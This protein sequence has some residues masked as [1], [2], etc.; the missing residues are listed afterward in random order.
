MKRI[1]P[2]LIV[3]AALF[4]VAF[5]AVANSTHH[6][7]PDFGDPL[8]AMR[9]VK[10]QLNLNTSQQQQWDTAVAQGKAARD[11][12]RANF[13]Q[14]KTALQT[15]LAKSEP[16][17]AAAATVHDEMEQQNSSLRKQAR[18]AWL[19]LYGTFTPDQKAVVRDAIQARIAKMQA[20]HSK[21]TTGESTN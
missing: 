18:S 14:S 12:M 1:L 8:S 21:A 4:G 11:A 17:L 16:D 3:T 20:M 19:A 7:H 15:E 2:A 13:G 10:D 5:W 6:R 9:A